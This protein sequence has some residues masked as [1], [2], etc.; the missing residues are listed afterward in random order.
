MIC[1]W[2]WK[3]RSSKMLRRR[4]RG[5]RGWRV[6]ALESTGLLNKDAEPGGTTIIDACNGF[7]ELIHL[8]MVWTVCYRWPEG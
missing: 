2:K 6:L 1:I 7:N 8:A 3:R 5:D 4:N